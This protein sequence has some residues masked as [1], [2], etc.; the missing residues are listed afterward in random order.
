MQWV[1]KKVNELVK[2]GVTSVTEM[3]RHLGFYIKKGA[4]WWFCLYQILGTTDLSQ[5][6]MTYITS[7][8]GPPYR[9]VTPKLIK[10]NWPIRLL[11]GYKNPPK[12]N[13]FC[14]QVRSLHQTFSS[15]HK[16]EGGVRGVWIPQTCTEIRINAAQNNTRKPQTALR[17]LP[18]NSYILQ[19]AWF[20]K[21]AILQL[22]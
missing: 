20:C 1:V 4:L 13:C 17:K 2:D 21:T 18:K 10:R 8:T 9:C 14:D 22:N 16:K 19:T 7:C 6:V 12:I 11:N 5:V 3:E 15:Q